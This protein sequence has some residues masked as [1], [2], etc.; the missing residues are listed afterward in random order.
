MND[1]TND[2]LKILLQGLE[3]C[4]FSG[5]ERDRLAAV[6][7]SYIKEIEL[8]NAVYDLV[9]A[10]DRRE[11]VIR[12]ILDSLSPFPVLEPL[13]QQTREGSPL[14]A[15]AGSG[16]GL[17]GIPLAAAFPDIQ[18]HLIERMSRRCAFLENCTAVLG[19]KN[20]TV[21]NTEAER[22]GKER[23]DIVVFRAFR[24]LDAKMTKTLLSL[25]RPEG[26]LAAYKGKRSKIE[27]EMTAI[28]G[29]A[30]KWRAE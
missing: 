2:D 26:Q 22:A 10:A 19:L 23:F 9:G 3:K 20:I 29:L 8:F 27:E 30:P 18:F 6:M 28:S 14:I 1:M 16:A 21:E 17:P 7:E 5:K 11:L 4:G 13:I 12:H 24:P 25:L 15:D